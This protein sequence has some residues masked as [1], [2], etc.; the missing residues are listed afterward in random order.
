MTPELRTAATEVENRLRAVKSEP[1]HGEWEQRAAEEYL[2]RVSTLRGYLESRS[3]S[4]VLIG[5]KGSGK[6][7]LL[8]ALTGLTIGEKPKQGKDFHRWAVLP[9]GSGGTTVCEIR[10]RTA[11]DVECPNRNG[12]DYGLTIVPLE[13]DS[14][15]RE[16][17]LFAEAL[18]ADAR[19]PRPVVDGESDETLDPERERV[20]RGITG[21]TMRR[22]P[23]RTQPAEDPADVLVRAAH[24]L[25]DLKTTLRGMAKLHERTQTEWWPSGSREDCLQSIKSTLANINS[26]REPTAAYPKVITLWIPAIHHQTGSFDVVFTDS[27]GYA[28]RLES[29]ADLQEFLKD[30]RCVYLLCT[31]FEDTPG[32][33]FRG[34]LKTV[35]RVDALSQ[36]ADRIRILIMDHDKAE[37]VTGADGDRLFGQSLR[38]ADC[39]KNLAAHNLERFAGNGGDRILAFDTLQDDLEDVRAQIQSAITGQRE[40]NTH[41]LEEAIRA[42]NE[43]LANLQ[44]AEVTAMQ[45]V[46]KRLLQAFQGGR[47]AADRLDDVV[48]G[49]TA[50]LGEHPARVRAMCRRD[51]EY[52][53]M[54][55]Y[56]AV[57]V[58]VQEWFQRHYR[59]LDTA[60]ETTFRALENDDRFARVAH[61]VRQRRTNY[62]QKKTATG[63]KVAAMISRELRRSMP[64]DTV[65]R[66]SSAEWTQGQGFR[67]RVRG[68]IE[69]FGKRFQQTNP[70][71][72][73]FAP[74]DFG[75]PA[76]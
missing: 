76:A 51:G 74:V 18:W 16:I 2:D 37:Q 58:A 10:V 39:Q 9:V 7:G 31:R 4:A 59:D 26:G 62:N 20:I 57:E 5:A 33:M 6:S 40:A 50:L 70:T 24:D 54:N 46:D 32:E 11:N 13:T 48:S 43:L 25:A 1:A 23:D 64:R 42:G 49:I 30:D 61:H 44:T 45:E 41:L 38:K 68:H 35:Q 73:Q 17:D 75:L 34:F 72:F 3:H 67:D 47:P 53:D 66:D 19:G 63:I 55:A 36:A 14:T 21:C 52:L 56:A 29:R 12:A 65:W 15:N 71:A 8:A 28:D 22:N 27:K 60:M 69:S